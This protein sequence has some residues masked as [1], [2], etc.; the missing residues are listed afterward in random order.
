MDGRVS[1]PHCFGKTSQSCPDSV[2]QPVPVF[3]LIQPG[4]QNQAMVT[5]L[6]PNEVSASIVPMN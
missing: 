2:R 4:E 6:L 1:S 3:A 5:L